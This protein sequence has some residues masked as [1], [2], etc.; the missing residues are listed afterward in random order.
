MPGLYSSSPSHPRDYLDQV[1]RFSFA[2]ETTGRQVIDSDSH[3]TRKRSHSRYGDPSAT[4]SFTTHLWGD[5]DARFTTKS[6]PP[7]AHDRY[8]LA[9]GDVGGTDRFSRQAGDYDD[10]FQLQK[11]RDMW[12]VPPTPQAGMPN[13]RVVIDDD[14]DD[15]STA[16]GGMVNSLMSIFGGVAGKLFQFV[17]VPFRGF[18]AGGGQRYGF[19]AQ[20]EIAAKLG[21]HDDPSLHQ[22]ATPV[23]QPTPTPSYN[24][25]YGVQSVDSLDN[26]RPRTI[27]R[28][29][30]GDTWVVVNPNGDTESRP[31]T[32]RVA[33]R[34]LPSASH[35]P[36]QIPRPTSR[37]STVSKRPS[38]I[39]V[40][41]RST[42]DRKPFHA[43]PK[44]AD[45]RQRAHSR[46]SLGSSPPT[47]DIK[48]KSPLPVESQRLISKVRQ[49]E[50]EDDARMRRMSS[51]MSAMLREA[52]EALG[53]KIDIDLDDEDMDFE[54]PSSGAFMFS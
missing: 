51:Q 6:P 24:D 50:L 31:S 34:R 43:S 29:R 42:I 33:E 14:D 39:P 25:N 7:L 11:Q 3:E 38:L 40:S 47:I 8:E 21:L 12:S 48:P 53:S 20:D 37:P 52:R 27:K 5:Y 32:P 4:H 45:I 49:E 16:N 26:E 36:S 15:M 13:Q 10:Y 19:D 35:T 46:L 18:Q 22:T 2:P 41:R 23:Q 28:L 30:T 17:T 1:R 54:R 44:T 9:G